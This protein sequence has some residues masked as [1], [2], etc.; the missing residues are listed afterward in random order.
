MSNIYVLLFVLQKCKA[1]I[2]RVLGRRW[3]WWIYPWYMWSWLTFNSFNCWTHTPKVKHFH[4]TLSQLVFWIHIWKEKPSTPVRV[5]SF[6]QIPYSLLFHLSHWLRL[7]STLLFTSLLPL[8]RSTIVIPHPQP[9]NRSKCVLDTENSS[10]SLLCWVLHLN[11]ILLILLLFGEAEEGNSTM[12][13]KVIDRNE[14]WKR[15]T[16][17]MSQGGES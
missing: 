5:I 13:V 8:L 10:P 3:G 15:A 4:H 7:I 9:E 14:A 6:Q 17:F 11:I 2:I 16:V 12:P 1:A